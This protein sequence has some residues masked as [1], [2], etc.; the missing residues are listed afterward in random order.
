MLTQPGNELR[1]TIDCFTRPGS[2]QMANK[3]AHQLEKDYNL[4]HNLSQNG[5]FTV[6]R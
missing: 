4:L 5:F 3:D 2:I 6:Q 1:K